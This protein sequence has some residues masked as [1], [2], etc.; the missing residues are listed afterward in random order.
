VT[1]NVYGRYG[2]FVSRYGL[3]LSS[4]HGQIDDI[5]K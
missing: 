4:R 2:L 1:V 3:V 5:S